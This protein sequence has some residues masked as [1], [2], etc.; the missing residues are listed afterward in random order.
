MCG[1]F[2]VVCRKEDFEAIGPRIERAHKIQSH[3]GPDMRGEVL[4][5]TRGGRVVYLAHQRLSILDLSDAGRQPM[6]DR[7]QCSWIAYNGEVYNY[8]ELAEAIGFESIGGSDT[9]VVL[10][11][12]RRYGVEAS[13]PKFNGMWGIAWM[14]KEDDVLYLTRDRAGV[15]PLYYTLRDDQLFFASEIKTLLVLAGRR[16]KINLQVVGEY[17]LQSLQDASDAT[18]FADIFAI[19]P[20]S[21]ARV[22]LSEPRLEVKPVEYWNPF[23]ANNNP[24]DP[25]DVI[26]NVRE[27]VTDAVK[28]RLRADVPVGVLLSGGV[29]SSII[30][31]CVKQ[32]VGSESDNVTVLSAVSPGM[33]GDESH[34]ID[35]VAAHLN[36]NPIKVNTAW[37]ANESMALLR[38]VTWANDT[39]LGSFS[40]VAFYLLMQRAHEAGIKVVLSGQGA[41]E[42]FCGYRK[43]L[44]FY[45]QQLARRKDF[46]GLLKTGF[47]FWK[48][49]VGLSQFNL[50]EARRYLSRRV[51]TE[52]LGTA[53]KSAFAPL[54]LGVTGEGIAHRQWLDYRNFSVP[55]LTHY[56]DRASM[57]FSREVRLPFLDYRVVELMLNAPIQSKLN[58]G[59]TKYSLRKAF[60]ELL[61][62]EIAWRKDKQGFSMP[63]EEWLRG[64]LK[65]EW[66]S[67]L[68]QNAE[69]FKRGILDHNGLHAKFER[70]CAK[71]SGIWY[72]EVFAP[73]ALEIWFQEFSEFID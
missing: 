68:H 67:V 56:E 7:A 3:R 13:L 17:L 14:S 65:S 38:K 49:G 63:Q 69:V 26:G 24:V 21:Y 31:A 37:G 73:L 50:T 16:Q 46:V 62:P 45:L 9:E 71:E 53:L 40:N 58:E 25:K 42:L 33:P 8:R 29:D 52:T 10:E 57:A 48:N 44:A 4:L 22:P 23:A 30:A 60:S 39:P 54:R 19:K 20:G 64:E 35:R 11:Y 47:D 6:Q 66:L 34:F 1:L 12:F 5:D 59:W 15:K 51:E 18:F 43:Y 28:L 55:Y 72:R 32:V 36:L 70:F 27:I 2:G 61:P 41:D